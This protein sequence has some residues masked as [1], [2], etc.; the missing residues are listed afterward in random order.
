MNRV[1]NL[2]ISFKRAVDTNIFRDFAS[3]GCVETIV[4]HMHASFAEEITT[5]TWENFDSIFPDSP[6][7][8]RLKK[9]DMRIK[10]RNWHLG[11]AKRKLIVKKLPRL[12]SRKLLYFWDEL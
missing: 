2:I 4:L 8:F 1:K 9:F 3:I 12:I 7:Q 5:V 6:E 10:L 11:L